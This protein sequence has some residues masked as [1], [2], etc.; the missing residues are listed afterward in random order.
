M[1]LVRC[2]CG[3]QLWYD[4]VELCNVMGHNRKITRIQLYTNHMNWIWAHMG[5][6]TPPK[7]HGIRGNLI[8]NKLEFLQRGILVLVV[9]FYFQSGCITINSWGLS[10]LWSPWLYDSKMPN[11]TTRLW[12]LWTFTFL[13]GHDQASGGNTP[14]K[15]GII[16]L[17]PATHRFNT[18]KNPTPT[19]WHV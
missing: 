17:H 3:F 9:Q 18:Y 6:F 1:A 5:R 8:I 14:C 12:D 11:C 7:C 4:M 13:S 19:Y 2:P 15:I 10:Y 16:D